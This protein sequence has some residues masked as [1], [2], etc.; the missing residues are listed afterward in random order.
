MTRWW[1]W[2]TRA[3]PEEFRFEYGTELTAAFHERYREEQ[4]VARLRFCMEAA[5]DVLATASKERYHIM[6][7][8]LVHGIRRLIAQPGLA[9]VA[10][11]SRWASERKPLSRFLLPVAADVAGT[12]IAL[13]ISGSPS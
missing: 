1:R 3:Y 11:L 6:I 7:R 12:G 9:S 5:A 8:D 2:L 13:V 10:I 4:G